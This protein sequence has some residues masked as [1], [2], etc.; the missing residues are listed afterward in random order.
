M[1]RKKRK[2]QVDLELLHAIYTLQIEWQRIEAIV[3][4][5]IEPTDRSLYKEKLAR[6]KYLFLLREARTRNLNAA[7]YL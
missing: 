5:S 3:E 1:R 6:S 7:K 2:K 4:E